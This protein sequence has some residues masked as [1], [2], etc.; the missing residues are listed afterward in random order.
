M[1]GRLG[2][3]HETEITLDDG[4]L[5]LLD[6]PLAD[7]AERFAADGS[8]LGRLGGRPP[9][10]PVLSELFEERRLEVRRL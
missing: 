10:V 1:V 6:G 9:R 5:G 3:R 4:R 2:L 7:V 8:L